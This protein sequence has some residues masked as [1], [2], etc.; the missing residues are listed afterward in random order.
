MAT[1]PNDLPGGLN[2][3]EGPEDATPAAVPT[4]PAVTA[5]AAEIEVNPAGSKAREALAAAREKVSE[6]ASGLKDQ[7]TGKARD[8]AAMGKDKTADGLDSVTRLMDD[9]A[10]TIDDKVGAQY[11]DYARKASSAIANVAATL[12]SK[13]VDELLSDAR[14]VVRKSPA[15]AVGAAVVAGF[16][17]A[18][19]VRAGTGSG[20]G[21]EDRSA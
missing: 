13:D 8:Y 15:L 19:L 11:G 4:A 14:E 6:Q 21:G 10:A 20:G 16:V 5:T 9:A 17:I 7:A 18:R 12:R 2:D 3:G 1:T